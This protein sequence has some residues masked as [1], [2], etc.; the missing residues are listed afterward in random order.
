MNWRPVLRIVFAL[1]VTV[2]CMY[3]FVYLMG[4]G[5]TRTVSALSAFGALLIVVAITFVIERR[6]S[7]RN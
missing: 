4:A 6:I 1:V 2:A 7:T 3:V 5:V